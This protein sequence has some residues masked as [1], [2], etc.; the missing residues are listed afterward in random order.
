M[1]CLMTLNMLTN[2]LHNILILQTIRLLA[3]YNKR[4]RYF[5]GALV[6]NAYDCTIIHVWMVKEMRLQF[7]G[8]NLMALKSQQCF[9]GRAGGLP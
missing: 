2:S 6:D 9:E 7:S 8:G 4:Q 1:T 5:A 3:L